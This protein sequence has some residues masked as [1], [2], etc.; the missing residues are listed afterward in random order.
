MEMAMRRV[1][2]GG[3]IAFLL[4]ALFVLAVILGVIKAHD[5]PTTCSLSEGVAQ[6]LETVGALV[7]AVVVSELS[8]T[9]PAQAP[10]TRLGQVFPEG[11]MSYVTLVASVYIVVWLLSGLALVIGGWVLYP[12]V[13]QL[14][15]A[16]KAWLGVAIGAAY[17]YFGISPPQAGAQAGA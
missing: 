8:I 3:L 17:A 4:L 5:C 2:F 15:S 7:S 16:A 13:A 10:G 14:N 12:T 6:L 11:Q 9:P 1:I